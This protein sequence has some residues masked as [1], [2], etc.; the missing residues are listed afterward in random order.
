MLDII[1]AK[2]YLAALCVL[3]YLFLYTES[4]QGETL[5]YLAEVIS[6]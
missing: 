5:R 2:Q 3:K 6:G 4:L 1:H